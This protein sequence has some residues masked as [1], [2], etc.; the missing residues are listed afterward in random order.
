MRC[1]HVA[2]EIVLATVDVTR[3]RLSTTLDVALVSFSLVVGAC[4]PGQVFVCCKGFVTACE[5]T[6]K[7]LDVVLL[8]F[9][10]IRGTTK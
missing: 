4:V 6:G 5:E 9:S 8:V 1:S 7:V 10:K 2:V 3:G